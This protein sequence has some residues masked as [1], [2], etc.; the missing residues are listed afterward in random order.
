[1]VTA[2]RNG[3]TSAALGCPFISA[4]GFMGTDDYRVDLPEGY[5]LKEAYIAEAIASADV[6][7]TL[8]HFKGHGVGIIGGAI[9]N[10]GIGAQSKRGKL[11]VHLS[12]HPKYGFSSSSIFHPEN[13]KG[14]RGEEGWEFLEEICPYD[15]IHVTETSIE[16]EK[17]KCCDCRACVF[18]LLGRGI[19]ELP[20][21]YFK[22]LSVAIADGC[23]GATKAVGKGKVAFINIAVDLTP[24]CDC[25]GFSDVPILPNLGVFASYDPVAVD[26]ACLDRA[27]ETAGL[28]GS[29][30]EDMDVLEV[31]KR[32]FEACSPLLSGLS[33]DI[34]VNTGEIIGLGTRDYDL[35]QVDEKP[36]KAFVFPPDPRPVGIRLREKCA[37]IP[38]FPHERYN[39]EGFLREKA[40]DV[41]WANA[42]YGNSEK[43]VR[44][45]SSGR[46]RS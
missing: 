21:E 23:L 7:I 28:H 12:G 37:K 3:N 14:R 8:T 27:K 29:S 18:P 16:W 9:K 33:E 25:A 1:M 13:F 38:L 36:L 30:A 24:G 46:R 5:I 31:G 22:A 32:K 44:A 45:K 15:L 6:L 11:N 35:V 41:E 26:K 39:G 4:D 10:L 42:Y 2:E 40:V 34:Q 43:L 17:E 20:V 19:I